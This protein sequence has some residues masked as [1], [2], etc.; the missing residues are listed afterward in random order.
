MQ[1]RKCGRV[2]QVAVASVVA[3]PCTLYSPG[4]SRSH[5]AGR[6]L[7]PAGIHRPGREAVRGLLQTTLPQGNPTSWNK[8]GNMCSGLGGKREW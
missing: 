2:M 8:Y 3:I 1:F 5:S 7:L 6:G 4:T